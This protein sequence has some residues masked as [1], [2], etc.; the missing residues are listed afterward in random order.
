MIENI[1]NCKVISFVGLAK[2]VGKTTVLNYFLKQ[3]PKT[4][5][6][7]L[8]VE[9]ES[10][11]CNVDCG[12]KPRVFLE[13]GSFFTTTEESIQKNGLSVSI[14]EKTRIVTPL[15]CVVLAEV[16]MPGFYE[17]YGAGSLE[18][19]KRIIIKFL[20]KGAKR[21]FVDGALFRMGHAG[22]SSGCVLISG[23]NVNAKAED[24]IEETKKVVEYLSF[25]TLD[26]EKRKKPYLI[27]EGKIKEFDFCSVLNNE[28]KIVESISKKT[29]HIYIPGA[30]TSQTFEK[31]R[32]L[33]FEFNKIMIIIDNGTKCF[34]KRDEYKLFLKMRGRIKVLNSINLCGVAVNSFS[35][36]LRDFDPKEF[37]RVLR[38]ELKP[39]NVEDVLLCS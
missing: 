5:V 29:T 35:T 8:G 25:R 28:K 39:L 1:K 13:K 18:R 22:I 11:D 12:K 37:L 21:V 19:T 26:L 20:E 38:N 16:R 4:A 36:F 27:D 17:I 30:F 9:G 32:R 34:L 14:I 3:L 6:T 33:G 7:S 23:S 24:V 10:E 31:F 15:G 2:D